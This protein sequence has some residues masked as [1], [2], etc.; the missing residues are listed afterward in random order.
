MVSHKTFT[1]A[2]FRASDIISYFSCKRNYINKVNALIQMLDNTHKFGLVSGQHEPDKGGLDT[3]DRGGQLKPDRG[4][5]YD[6]ILH[7]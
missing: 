5:L 1:K 4:G 2:G 6:R 7:N 3:P